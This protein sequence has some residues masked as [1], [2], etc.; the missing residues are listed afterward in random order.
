M[1]ERVSRRSFLKLAATASAAAAIPGC[2][3]AARKLI[4]YVVPD[5]NVVPGVPSFFAT[6]CSECPAGCG[7]IARIREGRVIKLEGNPSDPIGRGSLCARG[8]AALQGL[9]NPDRLAHPQLRGERGALAQISWQSAEQLFAAKLAAASKAGKDRVAYFGAPAGPTFKKIVLAWLGAHNSSRA[10][11]YEAINNEPARF[12]TESLF[13]RRDLPVYRIDQAEVLVSFGADFLETW[14]SP[15]EL[16]RQYA[17]FRTP[18]ER[19][20]ALTIGRSIYVGPRLSMTASKCDEWIPVA[21]SAMTDVAWSV[22]QAM[23]KHPALAQNSAIDVGAVKNLAA[24]YDPAAVSARTKVPAAAIAQIADAFV[25]G[26]GALA[27]AGNDDPAAHVAVALMNSIAGSFGK[28]VMFL[29]GAPAVDASTA[30]D[31]DAAINAMREGQIDVVVIAGSNPVFTMPPA[32][33]VAAALQKVSFVVWAGGVPDETA[34]MASLLL[35]A[36]HPLESWRDSA[37]RAGIR[38]LGQPVMQPVFDSKPIGDILLASA[39][40]NNASLPWKTTADAIKVEWL[41]MAPKANDVSSEDFWVKVRREG[42]LFEDQHVSNVKPN[43]FAIKLAT[44]ASVQ[45][46]LSVFAYP[47]IFFYDGRGADKPWLQEL[48]EP[49]T[50]IVWDSW[51]EI[52]PDTARQLGVATDDLIEVKTGHGIIEVPALIQRTVHPG[53]IAIPIGQGHSA[54]GRYAKGVGANAWAILP[55][56]ANN[57][58]LSVHVTGRSRKLVTPLGKSDMMGRSIVEAMSIEQLAAGKTPE[59]EAEQ[60]TGPYEMYE[61]WKYPGH[62]W[63]M[64][65]DVN[66]CT[67][68]SACVT[69]CYAENNVP[70]VGKEG[71]DRG[72]IMS[73]IRI[74]R[75]FPSAQHVNAKPTSG[76]RAE[77]LED[78]LKAPQLY[79]AP[80][81]CQQC[82]HA[83][84]E[85]VCPVFASYHTEEGLNGQIY[86]RCVGTRYCENNCP[87][88]VRR[89]NW[90]VPE[91]PAPLNLQ[92]NPDVTVRGAGVMEKCTFCVQRIQF[93]ELNAKTEDRQLRDG[94]IVTAC[95]Q[96]CPTRAIT[97]GDINDPASAM[98]RRRDDNKLRNYRSLDEI[99][100]LPAITYL[101]DLYREKGNA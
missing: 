23:L 68:C 16:A 64:T 2:E 34:A 32:L 41:A 98:M 90:F 44:P 60:V 52:H 66:A 42:G 87:Y 14:E 48:P 38:G 101:R 4:P 30:D 82:D 50:Q 100:T 47:H 56:R 91:W 51:A 11:F 49:V 59:S 93:G 53:V 6:T 45:P 62:K 72:R 46:Q 63:G 54:Y 58:E 22:L 85:P 57:A 5:E 94:E 79:L 80:M 69:A 27:I 89:F 81:L 65:I 92:L 24:N 36:H 20:G 39:A 21:P 15:V 71:V 10:I 12:A 77:S 31:V 19:R 55:A 3:P 43:L 26:E 84:C 29:D 74:E 73:W 86:N 97:F 7:V 75:Y 33:R 78:Q 13:G 18:K 25:K 95:A 99:N 8:Q 76:R 83:P 96:A 70:V 88:K 28:T 9:Y 40:A 17:L 61:P 37:P 35:P 1:A 67:G